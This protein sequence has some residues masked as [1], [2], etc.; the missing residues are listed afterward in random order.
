[1]CSP[2]ETIVL[3]QRPPSV[4]HAETKAQS[5]ITVTLLSQQH[6]KT[7]K[8]NTADTTGSKMSHGFSSNK[9]NHY[10]YPN[11]VVLLTFPKAR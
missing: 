4:T 3:S 7:P 8:Q 1:M 9:Y 2:L 6:L 11:I 5:F 10:M